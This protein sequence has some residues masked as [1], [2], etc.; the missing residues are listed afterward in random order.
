MLVIRSV[1]QL[2]FWIIFFVNFLFIFFLVYSLPDS[3]IENVAFFAISYNK[4]GRRVEILN[5]SY[6]CSDGK[7]F[8]CSF[9]VCFYIVLRDAFSKGSTLQKTEPFKRYSTGLTRNA[10]VS[11]SMKIL[12]SKIDTIILKSVTTL[13][14][15]FKVVSF[16]LTDK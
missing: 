11:T 2:S 13:C 16:E 10:I 12:S 15:N 14:R 7:Q 9:G 6:C 4:I 1:T 5:I 3:L 8:N